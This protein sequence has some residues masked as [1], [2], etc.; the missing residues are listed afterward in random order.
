MGWDRPHTHD[1]SLCLFFGKGKSGERDGCENPG[2]RPE[3]LDADA[4]RPD[5]RHDDTDVEP[6]NVGPG[7]GDEPEVS[8]KSPPV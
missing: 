2:D 7:G 6:D 1:I 3:T 5:E 4:P 8:T